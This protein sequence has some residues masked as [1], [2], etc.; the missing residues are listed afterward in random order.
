MI[1]LNLGEASIAPTSEPNCKDSEKKMI[2]ENNNRIRPQTAPALRIFVLGRFEVLQGTRLIESEQWRSGKARGLFKILLTRRN[3]AINRHEALELLW[4]ELDQD[5]A[6]NNLNQAVYSLRRTLE[7]DL[8]RASASAYL[9][10]EGAKLQLQSGL[11]ESIDLDEFKR[12]VSQAQQSGQLGA[13]EA[14]VTLYAG[15]YLPEDLYEDWSVSRREALRQQWIEL[16]LQTA[17]VCRQQ[18]LDEKYQQYLYQVLESDFANEEA[19]QKLMESL[20]ET[21]RREE[22]LLFYRNFSTRLQNR[23]SIE[24]MAE[25]RELYQKIVAGR[26][27]VRSA[28]RR[29]MASLT[30]GVTATSYEWPASSLSVVA[31]DQQVVGRQAEQALWQRILSGAGGETSRLLLLVGEAGVGKTALA[32][33]M[34]QAARQAGRVVCQLDCLSQR[35]D[36]PFQGLYEL[37]EQALG[38]LSEAERLECLRHCPPAFRYRVLPGRVRPAEAGLDAPADGA[39]IED[40]LAATTQ[41]LAWV[42]RTHRLVIVLD[43][44]PALPGP[45]LSILTHWLSQPLLGSLAVVGTAWPGSESDQTELGGWLNRLNEAQVRLLRLPRLGSPDLHALLTARFGCSLTAS[46]LLWLEKAS[47]GNPRLALELAA[48]SEA[49]RGG[50]AAALPVGLTS[51]VGRMVARLSQP[52]QVLLQLAALIGPTFS[53]ELLHE[54]VTFRQDGGGWWLELTPA[55]LGHSLTE[56]AEG[57]WIEEQ[58]TDYRFTYPML[59]EVSLQGLSHNQRRCWCEII[60]WAQQKIVNRIV[61][62]EIV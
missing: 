22:A 8:A 39:T 49:V 46:R 6:A 53:F 44:L 2:A 28:S 51:Y 33:A 19:A 25:T 40:V 43:N 9:K 14:A 10:T 30:P 62:A 48:G 26:V 57:G 32:G 31:H 12:L 42:G 11:L 20:A 15:D 3:Y 55:Q 50:Q 38:W 37:S 58:L 1:I 52:A 54:I 56:L 5:R 13:Y 47:Q 16:L 7:P 18:G 36:L 17:E 35:I 4:P 21:G 61:L 45:A 59:A 27:L 29:A 24:P 23:L 34:A 41:V 60:G